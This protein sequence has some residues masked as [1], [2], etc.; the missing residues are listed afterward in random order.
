[1]LREKTSRY[2]FNSTELYSC[3]DLTVKQNE[4]QKYMSLKLQT[5]HER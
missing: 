5:K 2:E 3:K 1:M 4:T